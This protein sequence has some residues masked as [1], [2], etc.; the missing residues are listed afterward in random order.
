MMLSGFPFAGTPCAPHAVTP[1]A[2]NAHTVQK[3][4]R[5]GM[6]FMRKDYVRGALHCQTRS[7]SRLRQKK[8]KASDEKKGG[9]SS[10]A[11]RNKY[12]LLLGLGRNSWRRG[13]ESNRLIEILQTSAFPLGYH[14]Q[15]LNGKEQRGTTILF[16]SQ[17]ARL[18]C[19]RQK[20]WR[21]RRRREKTN[22]SRVQF[23][24]S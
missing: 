24:L 4:E 16:S 10:E 22:L 6:L 5:R 3:E 11:V 14:A 23:F 1:N 8:Q 7:R 2:D 20:N 13:S 19:P 9:N 18:F 12:G 17:S 15:L 21:L